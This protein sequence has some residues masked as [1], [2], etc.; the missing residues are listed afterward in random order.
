MVSVKEELIKEIQALPEAHAKQI[1]DYLAFLKY[2]ELEAARQISRSDETA[3]TTLQAE[4][5]KE[6]RQLA[7]AAGVGYLADLTLEDMLAD[8]TEEQ[9]HEVVETGPPVGNEVW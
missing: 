8:F 1:A 9:R 5:A 6:D 2:R 3:L 4:F 7:E